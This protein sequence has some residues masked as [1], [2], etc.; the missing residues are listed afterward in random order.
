MGLY[1]AIYVII[2]YVYSLKMTG[3]LRFEPSL[4]MTTQPSH[5]VTPA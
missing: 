1:K 5:L 2:V 4:T 3:W